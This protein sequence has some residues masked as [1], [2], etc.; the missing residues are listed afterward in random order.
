[1]QP[2]D[3]AR[4]VGA[5][6]VVSYLEPLMAKPAPDRP[7]LPPPPPEGV[8][9]APAPTRTLQLMPSLQRRA[10]S[11]A[12]NQV[13]SSLLQRMRS[14][15]NTVYAAQAFGATLRRE[16]SDGDRASSQPGT[17]VSADGRASSSLQQGL[18]GTRSSPGF[19]S[20][21]AALKQAMENERA[22]GAARDRPSAPAGVGLQ[23]AAGGSASFSPLRP[24]APAPAA[25]SSSS[26]AGQQ[27][28]AAGGPQQPSSQAA[29]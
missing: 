11:D 5:K 23:R 1:V 6:P 21:A 2:V 29:G 22:S 26:A 14:V 10:P 16:T 8:V 4:Y 19:S 20:M 25:G 18:V 28:R 7:D 17:T 24:T 13:K 9:P 3:N 12:A 27:E 15:A